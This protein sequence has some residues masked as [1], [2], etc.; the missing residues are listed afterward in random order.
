MDGERDRDRPRTRGR[1]GDGRSDASGGA[2]CRDLAGRLRLARAA[3]LWERAWPALWPA[4]GIAGAFL[5]VALLD[6]LPALPFWAHA[7]VL[8]AFAVA[9]AAALRRAWPAFRPPP[10]K[11]ARRRLERASGLDHRPLE[12]LD[13]RLAVGAG[14]AV[15]EALWRAHRARVLASLGRL[16]V[17]P[18]R[19]GL[20]KRDPVAL[21]AAVLLLLTIAVAA[22]WGEFGERIARAVQ[23][24]V[25]G[26]VASAPAELDIWITPP[27]YTALAPIFLDPGNA[28]G[29]RKAGPPLSVPAGSKVLARIRG[30]RGV[31]RLVIGGRDV[32]FSRVDNDNYHVEAVISGGEEAGEDGTADRLAV[33]QGGRLLGQWGLKVV[34]DRPPTID[35]AT[36]PQR[37]LRSALRIEYMAEDDYGLKAAGATIRRADGRG[38]APIRI[39]LPLP[40]P[41]TR[42]AR[43][44]SYLDLTPHPWAGLPVVIRL[45]ALDGRDQRGE[46]EDF[47]MVLPERIFLHPVAAA[48]IAER[49]KLTVDPSK[50]GSVAVALGAIASRPEHYFDDIVVFLALTSARSRLF[51]DERPEAIAEVQQ[52]LWDT[53]LRIEDGELSLAERDL[54]EVQDA[55]MRALERGATDEELSRLIDELQQTLDKYLQALMEQMERRPPSDEELAALMRDPD[56]LVLEAQDLRRM[57]EEI[58]EL[59][60]TGARDAARQM[61][62]QLREMLE[63]LRTAQPLGE[64]GQ[65]GFTARMLRGLDQLTDRQR[66]L[67]DRT[68]RRSQRGRP[69]ERSAEG[70]AD[71]RTQERLRR[72]LGDIMRQ[73]GE[74]LGE[75]P[76]PLGR[77]ERAMREAGRALE[78]NAP[79]E[80]VDPQG[81]AL[82]QMREG[83]RALVDEL[84]RQFGRGQGEGT[85][86]EAGRNS[87]DP[88][89]RLNP[90]F[91][92]FDDDG[93]KVP[94]EAAL[95][96]A[97][98]ILRELRRRAGER[99]RPRL[100][101]EYLNRLL[102]RF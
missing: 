77:A 67:L 84:A 98:E 76:V 4:V 69:G 81:R 20:A 52:L 58:R 97:R 36:A 6:V 80:A 78:R 75:I 29:E 74:R 62:A 33:E 79:G 42:K 32:P 102:R 16:R 34:P 68:F 83:R 99:R 61:L 65:S 64:R 50:R 9:E 93:V 82:E 57:L 43:D 1:A 10:E 2:P 70:A 14:D 56:N 15:S 73:L 24:D 94:S 72:M 85:G 35:Y 13:D 88:F 11:A 86:G 38:D 28:A 48:I 39:E 100:E 21:R 55:L 26:L 92:N 23:P 71:A 60:Q 30:G 3:L 95:Q 54:R 22:G 47:E 8:A 101:R 12:L 27:D 5:A 90:G 19:P 46:S 49:R 89:G 31:P 59:A 41:N 7:G 87:R 25:S 37:T 51:H 45:F 63:N 66:Q 53:A 18:P 17:G 40:A 44:A 91:A 96:R